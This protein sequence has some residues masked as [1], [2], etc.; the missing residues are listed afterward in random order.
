MP[1]D[2]YSEQEEVEEK[3]DDDPDKLRKAIALGTIAVS[4][5]TLDRLLADEQVITLS[6]NQTIKVR[7]GF[8]DEFF[9]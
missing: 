5:Y 9:D 6:N 1:E 2:D 3:K 7:K 4:I 8:L